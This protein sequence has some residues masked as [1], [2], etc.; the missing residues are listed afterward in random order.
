[1]GD[2]CERCFEEIEWSYSISGRERLCARCHADEL[3]RVEELAQTP[4]PGVAVEL[5][6]DPF[7]ATGSRR[8]RVPEPPPEEPQPAVDDPWL[9]S[10]EAAEVRLELGDWNREGTDRP[11]FSYPGNLN[12]PNWRKKHGRAPARR[13]QQ[14][15]TRKR[16]RTESKKGH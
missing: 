3:E 5:R 12:N 7:E 6:C 10:A 16:R 15:N 4:I 14:E 8:S 13:S 9:S 1:M 11:A 2:R